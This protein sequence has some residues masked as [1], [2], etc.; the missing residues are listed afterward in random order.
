MREETSCEKRSWHLSEREQRK[1]T[2]RANMNAL[3]RTDKLSSQHTQ[4]D[5]PVSRSVDPL[6]EKGRKLSGPAPS[7]LRLDYLPCCGP[8]GIGSKPAIRVRPS[9]TFLRCVLL[10]ECQAKSN[11]SDFGFVHRSHSLVSLRHS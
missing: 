5:E 1:R 3:L 11:Q 6:G 4:L 9:I 7:C 8:I 10:Q 2:G